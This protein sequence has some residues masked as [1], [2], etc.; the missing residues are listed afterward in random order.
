V[1]SLF[2]QLETIDYQPVTIVY[3]IPDRNIINCHDDKVMLFL[4]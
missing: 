1:V 2:D 4:L 3:I